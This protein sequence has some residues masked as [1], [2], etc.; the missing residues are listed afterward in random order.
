MDNQGKGGKSPDNNKRLAALEAGVSA[1]AIALTA[2]GFTVAGGEDPI[3]EA[4][5]AIKSLLTDRSAATDKI[6]ELEAAIVALEAKLAAGP[7][8][9]TEGE[10]AAIARAEKAEGELAAAN[11][12]IA[13]LK[14]DVEEA[15]SERNRLANELSAEGRSSTPP[16]SADETAA[17]VEAPAPRE[18]PENAR[19]VGPNYPGLHNADDISALLADDQAHGLELA[20]SNG[21]YEILSLAPIA[22]GA[23]D[24]QQ[25]EGRVM[26]GPPVYAKLSATDPQEDLHG[27]GLLMQGE[28]IAYCTFPERLTLQPGSE[29]RFDRAIIF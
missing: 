18:R 5:K 15:M 6:A 7:D 14:T 21:E 17:E 9:A 8:G 22:I 11:L 25:A 28:Q 2:N 19:D 20:F 4:V 29:R 23:K 10:I 12:E 16:A 26:V 27:M 3:E 24:L 1:L 13:E